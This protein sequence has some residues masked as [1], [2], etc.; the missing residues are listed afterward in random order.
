M[1]TSN[2]DFLPTEQKELDCQFETESIQCR[3][4]AVE[5]NF[6]IR[7]ILTSKFTL[8]YTDLPKDR[9]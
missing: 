7:K 4:Q 1:K 3:S 8:E 9:S 2:V 5:Q 6:V